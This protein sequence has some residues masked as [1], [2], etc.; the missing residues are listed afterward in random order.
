MCTFCLSEFSSHNCPRFIAVIKHSDKKPLRAHLPNSS[1]VQSIAAEVTGQ[2]A[3]AAS[4]VTSSR[5]QACLLDS[6]LLPHTVAG[7][8]LGDG[9]IHSSQDVP[10]AQANVDN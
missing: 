9:V 3:D 6:F 5:M 4:H 1:R 2:E 7:P 8:A 10:M